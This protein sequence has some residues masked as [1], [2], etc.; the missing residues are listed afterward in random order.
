MTHTPEKKI[1]CTFIKGSETFTTTCSDVSFLYGAERFEVT[2]RCD[3][4]DKTIIGAE[5]AE[6]EDFRG[7]LYQIHITT[8]SVTFSGTGWVVKIAGSYQPEGVAKK[9]NEYHN[10]VWSAVLYA[11]CPV[12][13]EEFRVADKKVFVSLTSN[14]VMENQVVYLGLGS[15]DQFHLLE[16][17]ASSISPMRVVGRL[18][19]THYVNCDSKLMRRWK[20]KRSNPGL[21][22]RLG[23]IYEDQGGSCLIS[24]LGERMEQFTKLG[25][26]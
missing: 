15:T 21:L 26:A 10:P 3:S 25:C 20:R 6:I 23:K 19:A 17:L 8:R 14:Y 12:P 22:K 5:R 11:R 9:A 7:T 2:L 18:N 13:V 16:F 1:R 24:L 4:F